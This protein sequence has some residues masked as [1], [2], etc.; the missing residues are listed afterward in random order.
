MSNLP[1]CVLVNKKNI[2]AYVFMQFLAFFLLTMYLKKGIYIE[3]FCILLTSRRIILIFGILAIIVLT[4]YFVFLN[5]TSPRIREDLGNFSL[6]IGM[7]PLS[8][9]LVFCS[10]CQNNIIA[11]ILTVFFMVYV[12]MLGVANIKKLLPGYAGKKSYFYRIL[13]LKKITEMI[14]YFGIVII[15]NLFVCKNVLPQKKETITSANNTAAEKTVVINNRDELVRK[16]DENTWKG[17][18]SKKRLE[19]LQ[20]LADYTTQKYLGCCKVTV[21][22]AVK[23][24]KNTWGWFDNTLP[25]SVFISCD[26]LE[27]DSVYDSAETILHEVYHH[28]EYECVSA[29]EDADLNQL[30]YFKKLESWR[31]NFLH[32]K[33]ADKYGDAYKDQPV[34]KDANEFAERTLKEILK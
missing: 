17:L 21:R 33:E 18:S 30:Y 28:Y 31:E 2:K 26:I 27:D 4:G 22:Q 29:V 25:E 15:V 8:L 14:S 11:V 16:F 5:K 23:L 9:I 3:K 34:E 7:L 24:K 20:N 19:Y 1:K 12:V 32:Y 13:Y 6:Y 10:C